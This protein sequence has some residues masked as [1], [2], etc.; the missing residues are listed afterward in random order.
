MCVW[1]AV[2]AIFGL[3]EIVQSPG[4]LRALS[5]TY[6]VAFFADA[7]GTAFLALGSVVLAVTGAEA[8]YADMGH[9]GRP[10][11]R[12]AWFV[13]VF[14][15]L[16]LNYFGQGAMVL[17]DPSTRF[18]PF[19]ELAPD[20]ALYPTIALATLATVIASQAVIS[21]A[22]SVTRQAVQ[23]GFLPRVE[24]RH[25]SSREI[26]QI[27]VPFVNWALLV[28]VLVLVIG[29]RSSTNLASAYGIAVTGTLAIDTLLF[30]VVV[31]LLWRKPW[32]IVIGGATCFLTVDLA[33]FTA[34]IPKIVH[35]GWFPLVIA[36]IVFAVLMTW[37]AGRIRV[38][39]A[40]QDSEVSMD[41]FLAQ[42]REMQPIRVPGTAVFLTASGDG[43]PRALMHNL[44]HNRVLHQHVVLFNA[45]TRGVPHVPDSE[46]LDVQEVG[47]GIV[48]VK[49]QYGFQDEPKI[50][51][52]LRLAAEQGLDIDVDHASYF[53]SHMTLLRGPLPGMATWR[54]RLYIAMSRNSRNAALYFGLPSEQVVEI[55]GHIEL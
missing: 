18:N 46:R 52:A 55:G 26:G 19:Y 22:F 7:P 11:I 25:T 4:I 6:A 21:G 20:W 1:F 47:P 30:F 54:K 17:D 42:V 39:R 50:P 53:L 32:W 2:L 27:Y 51:K 28:G 31:R 38:Q 41:T 23:L 13:L 48:R 3:S 16:L 37:R 10:A 29:F 43:A 15:A 14:P 34:N 40:V 12:R 45:G 8:L 36:A 33:F 9:F 44:D 5:P 49:A 35:G 24:I